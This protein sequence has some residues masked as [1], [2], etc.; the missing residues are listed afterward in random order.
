MKDVLVLLHCSG[1]M[2]NN[3]FI[4]TTAQT[5]SGYGCTGGVCVLHSRLWQLFGTFEIL[6]Q[7]RE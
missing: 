4:S 3:T 6:R 7:L 2:V 1:L 5:V